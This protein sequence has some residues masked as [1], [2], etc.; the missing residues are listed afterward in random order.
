MKKFIIIFLLPLLFLSISYLKASNS[1]SIY[2]KAEKYFNKKNY[3]Y[4]ALEYERLIYL[5]SNEVF[6]NQLLLKKSYCYKLDTNYQA[7]IETLSRINFNALN[8][9]MQDTVLYERSLSYYLLGDFKN[10][11]YNLELININKMNHSIYLYLLTL[12]ELERWDEAQQI[13][14]KHIEKHDLDSSYQEIY[15]N[16]NTKEK[17]HN[18]SIVLSHVV[19]GFGYFILGK[20]K[21]AFTSM[22]LNTL[23]GYYTVSSFIGGYYATGVIIGIPFFLRFY[24]G[25]IR[26]LKNIIKEKEMKRKIEL[27]QYLKEK[28]I[29]IIFILDK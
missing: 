17:K 9:E 2:E 10:A 4:A 27:N 19:P 12:N 3:T 18:V 13:F 29:E 8:I 11:F 28:I 14:L 26:N 15:S 25:G 20:P 1:D 16:I 24:F 7:S 6:K 5:T 22:L 23:T 21:E